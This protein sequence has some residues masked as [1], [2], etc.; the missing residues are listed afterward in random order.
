MCLRLVALVISLLICHHRWSLL[1]TC[2]L[3]LHYLLNAFTCDINTRGASEVMDEAD[4]KFSCKKWHFREYIYRRTVRSRVT[5][6]HASL[7]PKPLVVD[8]HLL[9]DEEKAVCIGGKYKH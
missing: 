4:E 2:F 7:L 8:Y 3:S 5:F 9:Q 6:D 1:F